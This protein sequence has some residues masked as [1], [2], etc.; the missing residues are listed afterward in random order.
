MYADCI[1][2]NEYEN[3]HANPCHGCKSVMN[4]ILITSLLKAV[5]GWNFSLML[6]ILDEQVSANIPSL[7]IRKQGFLV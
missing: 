7:K 4:P 6:I 1:D 3:C 5:N 2:N